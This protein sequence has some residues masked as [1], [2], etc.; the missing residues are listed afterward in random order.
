[1]WTGEFMACAKSPMRALRRLVSGSRHVLT[2]PDRQ[3]VAGWEGDRAERQ[4]P[5][6]V[7]GKGE[8]GGGAGLGGSLI[9]KSKY[10]VHG[11]LG[12]CDA[13]RQGRR[14]K[15]IPAGMTDRKARAKTTATTTAKA[16][17]TTTTT[18][19]LAIVVPTLPGRQERE[20]WGTQDCGWT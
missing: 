3:R 1:M 10:G 4:K 14:K 12:W 13:E 19:G 6:T 18:T 20:G 2:D 15:Q 9:S 16:K 8:G 7:F 11:F 17:A 5:M